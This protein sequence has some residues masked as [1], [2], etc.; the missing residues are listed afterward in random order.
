[1]FAQMGV[2]SAALFGLATVLWLVEETG[3]RLLMARLEFVKLVVNDVVYAVAA[4]GVAAAVIVT[5]GLTMNWLVFAMACGSAATIVAVV[6]QLPRDELAPPP[7]GETAHRELAGVATWRSG[8]LVMR[9]LG[10]L[11]VR[12]AVSSL[13]ST[14][15]LGLMEAGRL[16]TAPILTAAN[17]FGG[18]T[19][20][21]FTR[22]RNEGR[23]EM[24]LVV[25]FAAVSALGA[26]LYVPLAFALQGPFE[27]LADSPPLPSALV[28]SWCVYAMAYAA[29]IPVVN[30][31][32]S[33]MFSKEVF[34]GRVVD[35]LLIIVLSVVVVEI[36]GVEWVPMVMTFGILIGTAVPFRVLRRRGDLVRRQSDG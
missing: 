10:M 20:P 5:R 30:A 19:L 13:V 4:L 9:P 16:L 24:S 26:A 1:V 31:L 28:V 22:R 35:S 2:A 32:T 17:G 29:N 23:L 34:W 6:F 33:L 36:D 27:K 3:R 7:R 8:Q 14:A 11:L 12:V 15:A 21:F 18:F 25:K